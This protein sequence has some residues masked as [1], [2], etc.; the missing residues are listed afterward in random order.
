[1]I[2]WFAKE[3]GKRLLCISMPD[4]EVRR[5][6]IPEG[7]HPLVWLLNKQEVSIACAAEHMRQCDHIRPFIVQLMREEAE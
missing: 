6:E 3:E 7:E 5:V 4:G 1:M 2:P